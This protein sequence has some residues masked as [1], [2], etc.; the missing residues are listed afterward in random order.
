MDGKGACEA[1]QKKSRKERQFNRR[2]EMDTLAQ[3]VKREIFALQQ[4][5]ETIKAKNNE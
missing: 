1:L 4:Q 2:V 3:Q 5:M